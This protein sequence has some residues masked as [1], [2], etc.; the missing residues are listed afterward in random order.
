V[1]RIPRRLAVGVI[2]FACLGLAANSRAQVFELIT[3]FRHCTPEGCADDAHPGIP[4]GPLLAGA[5]GFFYGALSPD[6]RVPGV[7]PFQW[8]I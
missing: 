3:S 8:A 2:A 7:S 6:F 1:T 4:A 5:D